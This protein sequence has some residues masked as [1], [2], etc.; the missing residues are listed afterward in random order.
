MD[1]DDTQFLHQHKGFSGSSTFL[2]PQSQ[3]HPQI[4]PSPIRFSLLTTTESFPKLRTFFFIHQP[5]CKSE[6]RTLFTLNCKSFEI[7]SLWEM[8][9]LKHFF[10]LLMKELS[11]SPR[12]WRSDAAFAASPPCSR[13]G[14]TQCRA[15][16][17]VLG[18]LT[19]A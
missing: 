2:S 13:A 6:P 16:G 10:S 7:K 18:A 17:T 8:K 1:T 9:A 11:D 4:P 12:G 3:E 19:D 5:T 15:K 14:L